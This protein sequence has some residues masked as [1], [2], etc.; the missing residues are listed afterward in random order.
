[1][2]ARTVKAN[3]VYGSLLNQAVS[4]QLPVYLLASKSDFMLLLQMFITVFKILYCIQLFI[5][6]SILFI[7]S[8]LISD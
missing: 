4:V 1:M 7:P 6:V 5:N 2:F 8:S 3:V